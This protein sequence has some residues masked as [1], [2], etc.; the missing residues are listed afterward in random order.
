MA[1]VAAFGVICGEVSKTNASTSDGRK[2]LMLCGQRETSA[3]A[4][5]GNVKPDPRR[6]TAFVGRLHTDNTNR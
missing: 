2:K 4:E 6:I 1:E 5:G 3:S